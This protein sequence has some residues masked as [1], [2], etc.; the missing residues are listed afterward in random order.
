SARSSLRC[1]SAG[2]SPC[3][4][5]AQKKRRAKPLARSAG[6]QGGGSPLLATAGPVVGGRGREAA[7]THSATAPADAH[8]G[9]A[10]SPALLSGPTAASAPDA[11]P[12]AA[13]RLLRPVGPGRWRSG[14]PRSLGAAQAVLGWPG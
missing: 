6:R 7:D 3:R 10:P 8:S 1:R 14:S 12:P 13:D 5:E 11:P 9:E 4:R 2:T